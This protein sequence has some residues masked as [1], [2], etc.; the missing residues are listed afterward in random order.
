L[1]DVHAIRLK[2]LIVLPEYHSL[3][4]AGFFA[5]P[6]WISVAFFLYRASC[7]IV[8]SV[9]QKLQHCN[10]AFSRFTIE[11]LIFL[12]WETNCNWCGHS[13]CSSINE[14]LVSYTQCQGLVTTKPNRLKFKSKKSTQAGVDLCTYFCKTFFSAFCSGLELFWAP[15]SC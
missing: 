1:I 9:T 7:D 5:S 8:F 11:W 12:D 2:Y 10:D 6:C 13:S 4:S 14:L 3:R 15:S